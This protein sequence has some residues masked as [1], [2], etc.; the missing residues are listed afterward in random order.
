MIN[1]AMTVQQA[2]GQL[3]MRV[4]SMGTPSQRHPH[5]LTKAAMKT[6]MGTP[7]S[8]HPPLPHCAIVRAC[9]FHLLKQ[10]CMYKCSI[11]LIT[12][13]WC[14]FL[15]IF[16]QIMLETSNYPIKNARW[17]LFVVLISAPLTVCI[18]SGKAQP[19]WQLQ[20]V[21]TILTIFIDGVWQHYYQYVV[22]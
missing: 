2:L 13:Q 5:Q 18:I 14:N 6:V 15:C 9:D 7:S 16:I 11:G 4:S 19:I 8:R 17:H 20:D 22:K 1:D 3:M 12:N 10:F 21:V